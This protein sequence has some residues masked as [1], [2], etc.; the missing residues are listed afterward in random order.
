MS[1]SAVPVGRGRCPERSWALA[2]GLLLV[3]G[4]DG[5]IG[6]GAPDR[7]LLPPVDGT[8]SADAASTWRSDGGGRRADSRRRDSAR[9]ADG[10]APRPYPDVTAAG[11]NCSTWAVADKA[12][13]KAIYDSYFGST[14]PA[15]TADFQ[16]HADTSIL[17]AAIV[18]R[19][20][21]YPPTTGQSESTYHQLF[22]F[23]PSTF[24]RSTY[25]SNWTIFA[26]FD[27]ATDVDAPYEKV[28]TE[29]WVPAT[30]THYARSS[31]SDVIATQFVIRLACM[32]TQMQ[33]ALSLCPDCSDAIVLLSKND[34]YKVFDVRFARVSS[35]QLQVS[36]LFKMVSVDCSGNM[37]QHSQVSPYYFASVGGE[38]LRAKWRA[39]ISGYMATALGTYGGPTPVL[40]RLSS[41]SPSY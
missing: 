9:K 38:T 13:A 20:A 25:L 10:P 41:S 1:S 11:V 31:T 29:D 7:A 34:E 21:F 37:T 32:K 4:C 17:T 39:E 30:T 3:S 14:L 12:A 36:K 27:P 5:S 6:G 23:N 28:D 33:K 35:S 26:G 22:D 40:L 2:L 15:T 19:V 24:Q 8:P 18:D 16:W